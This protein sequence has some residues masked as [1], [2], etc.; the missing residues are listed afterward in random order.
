MRERG[1]GEKNERTGFYG[2]WRL[3]KNQINGWNEAK[4]MLLTF[5]SGFFGTKFF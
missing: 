3:S 1:N 5:T 4:L 2:V